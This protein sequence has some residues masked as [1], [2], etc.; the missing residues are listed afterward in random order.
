METPQGPVSADGGVQTTKNESTEKKVGSENSSSAEHIDLTEKG[1]NT[2]TEQNPPENRPEEKL[3]EL[4]NE[5]I[6]ATFTSRGAALKR[7][8]LPVE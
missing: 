7:L 8:L 5:F 2:S 1:D 4:R 3:V 6:V